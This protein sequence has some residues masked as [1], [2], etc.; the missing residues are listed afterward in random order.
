MLLQCD[1]G[2]LRRIYDNWLVHVIARTESPKPLQSLLSF[3]N[4]ALELMPG[5]FTYQIA[6]VI[7]KSK[8]CRLVKSD[9]D[10][11]AILAISVIE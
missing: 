5:T 1:V 3:V 11:L 9:D 2:F 6:C 7:G 4:R 10:S 8:L